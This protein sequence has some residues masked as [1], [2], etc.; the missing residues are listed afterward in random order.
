MTMT[1]PDTDKC[2][3]CAEPFKPDDICAT[4]IELLTVHA[5]CLDGCEIVDLET[6][7]P[8]DKPLTTYRYSEVMEP[9]PPQT[10]SNADGGAKP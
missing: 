4:D 1:N 10:K 9:A 8:T 7:E 6:G 3:I 5:E 2:P